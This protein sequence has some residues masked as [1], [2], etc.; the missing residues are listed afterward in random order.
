M[1]IRECAARVLCALRVEPTA[2]CV[3]WRRSLIPSTKPLERS[4]QVLGVS[5]GRRGGCA[6]R[7][8]LSSG[9]N[10][11]YDVFGDLPDLLD[12]T[13]AAKFWPFECD[14]GDRS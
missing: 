7:H 2:A 10:G 9:S 1:L 4:P 8:G 11:R 3:T 12:R 5:V 6:L 13:A 14:R